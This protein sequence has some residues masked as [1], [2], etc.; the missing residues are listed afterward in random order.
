MVD[1]INVHFFNSKYIIID[2]SLKILKDDSSCDGACQ[3]IKWIKGCFD[4]LE[5]K[6]VSIFIILECLYAYV[7]FGCLCI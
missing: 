7:R 1:L 3:V 2:L 6:Y 5:K 4:A